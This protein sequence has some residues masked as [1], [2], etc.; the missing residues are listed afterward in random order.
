MPNGCA[1]FGGGDKWEEDSVFGDA[2]RAPEAGEVTLAGT[3]P[4]AVGRE[5]ETSAGAACNLTKDVMRCD[6]CGWVCLRGMEMWKE[7]GDGDV[8]SWENPEAGQAST[9]CPHST[10]VVGQI[11]REGIAS[12]NGRFEP[13][14]EDV[15]PDVGVGTDNVR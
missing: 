15:R 9:T 11:V 3:D 8:A 1:G 7:F 14:V 10:E 12:A 4:S 2:V 5:L 13:L 6:S